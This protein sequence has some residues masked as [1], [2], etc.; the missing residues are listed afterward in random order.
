MKTQQHTQFRTWRRG[1]ILLTIIILAMFSGCKILDS[2]T[3]GDS[4]SSNEVTTADEEGNLVISNNSGQRLKLFNGETYLKTLS[5]SSSDF[6]VN[7]PNPDSAIL[8]LRLFKADEVSG[9]ASPG[10]EGVF[11][12]WNVILA[13]DT[14]TEHRATWMVQERSSE[15]ES[16]EITLAY[17]GGTANSVDVYLSGKAENGGAKLISLS[18]GAQNRKVGLEYGNYTVYF[19]Y[20]YSDQNSI[21]GIQEVG[22]K[23]KELV[24]GSEVPIYIVLNANRAEKHLQIPHYNAASPVGESPYGKIV[25]TNSTSLPVQIYSEKT[26]IENIIH[27]DKP[28]TNASTIAAGTSDDFTL[29]IGS[30]T[31][32]ALDLQSAGEVATKTIEI[33]SAGSAV[34]EITD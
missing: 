26:L 27:T 4:D 1:F 20:W 23:E 12:R 32:R 17:I 16:G 11:K 14:Q 6:L 28:I 8:D 25:I 24:S 34:W 9:T 5:D 7:I 19:R 21:Q 15:Y 33:T 29:P 2:I 18:P 13:A 22:W 3:G 31:L 10:L 30:Y